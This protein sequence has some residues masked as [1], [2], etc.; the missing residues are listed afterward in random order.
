M[1]RVPC[2]ILRSSKRHH[3]MLTV[4][5]GAFAKT[6]WSSFVPRMCVRPL[7]SE[8]WKCRV[9]ELRGGNNATGERHIM[10]RG[11]PFR[12]V[13]KSNKRNHVP[14][15]RSR[16]LRSDRRKRTMYCMRS[17]KLPKQHWSSVMHA[18]SS[19]FRGI[20][21]QHLVRMRPRLL[22]HSN[23]HGGPVSRA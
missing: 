3:G 22:R 18:V 1:P 5:S 20:H 23:Q 2:G 14:R 10:V 15:L 4:R 12:H 19:A 17:R 16:L 13:S 7:C 6:S 21:R 8:C 9:P 11:V